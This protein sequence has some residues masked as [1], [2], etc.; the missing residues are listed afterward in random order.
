MEL[1]Q[2]RRGG[3]LR[4]LDGT[5]PRRPARPRLRGPGTHRSESPTATT[6]AVPK[7]T[8]NTLTNA[9]TAPV[10]MRALR[11]NRVASA[12]RGKRAHVRN[13]GVIEQE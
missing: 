1:R 5:H 7:L 4:G 3:P 12:L 6:I 10:A 2:Q 9:I 13:H 8:P 11:P